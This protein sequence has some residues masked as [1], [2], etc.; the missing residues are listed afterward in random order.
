M[1]RID[2]QNL[3]KFP[4]NLDF[5][6]ILCQNSRKWVILPKFM[7]ILIELLMKE[8]I[9]GHVFP[10]FQKKKLGCLEDTEKSSFFPYFCF[11]FLK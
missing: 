1:D 2:L 8:N 7:V 5:E 6:Q 4:K 10:S 11:D 9:N 3:Q